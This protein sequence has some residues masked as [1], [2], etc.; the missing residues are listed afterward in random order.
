MHTSTD[1]SSPSDDAPHGVWS[2]GNCLV[3]ARKS[4]RLPARCIKTNGTEGVQWHA[5]SDRPGQALV[6]GF[7]I[8]MAL[9]SERSVS[10]DRIS[11]QQTQ[12]NL[13]LAE[14][15]YARWQRTGR[16]G[17]SLILAGILVF[18]AATLAYVGAMAAAVP[19]S[20]AN[21][22]LIPFGLAIPLAI[23]GVVYLVASHKPIFTVHKAT[24]DYLWIRGASPDYLKQL[25]RWQNVDKR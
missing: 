15:W 2:D 19:E 22:I 10:W 1:S 5:I 25:P 3:V 8:T 18:I 11:G 7:V 9:L 20:L 13:P 12:L 6:T 24:A 21:L 4:H 23:V 16:I 14:S 17:W